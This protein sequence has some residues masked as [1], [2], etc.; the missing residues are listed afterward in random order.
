MIPGAFRG[1]YLSVVKFAVDSAWESGLEEL[2]QRGGLTE[3][4]RG[5]Y[6][7]LAMDN[8]RPLPIIQKLLASGKL[9]EANLASSVIRAARKGN[10]VLIDILLASDSI[11]NDH[12]EDAILMAKVGGFQVVAENLRKRMAPAE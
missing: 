3:N 1:Q 2:L 8:E 12:L 11:S 10:Q 4:E 7:R 6:V 5:I 9:S